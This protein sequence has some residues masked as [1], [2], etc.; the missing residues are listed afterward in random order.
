MTGTMTPTSHPSAP[1]ALAVSLPMYDQAPEALR[2]FWGG[3]GG[4]MRDAG[5]RGVPDD[6]SRPADLDAHWRSPDTLLS[7]TCGY[8]LATALA[9]RVRL[10]GT[11]RYAAPGC[12]ASDYASLVV[13]RRDDP[14]RAVAELRDRRAAIN[15]R[16]SQ[17]GHNAL[18]ALV[19]PHA[20]E[21]RFFAEVI[22]MGEHGRSLRMIQEGMADVAAI[23]CVT[24]AM[25]ARHAP[26]AI[27]GLRILCVSEPCPGL[28]LITAWATPDEDIARLR[29]AFAAACADPALASARQALL[30]EGLE[31]RPLADYGR[32]LAMEARA[33]QLGYPDL[34]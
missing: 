17:S 27:D 9:D 20:R 30:L 24:Y 1:L 23:D 10:V 33:R 26:R 2:T 6:L 28:P 19:A 29:A 7:Q 25:T 11:P 8:P 4:H 34:A 21:G 15:G 22:E 31:V 18:R 12:Q 32:C 16:R 14:A 3:L 13:V 5:L